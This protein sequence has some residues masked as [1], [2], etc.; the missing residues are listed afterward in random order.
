MTLAIV[1]VIAAALALAVIFRIAVSQ[2]LR[3]SPTANLT[4]Q[5]QAIDVEAFRNLVNPSE[6]D[7]LRQRLPSAQFRVVRRERLR[8]M[9]AY[10]QI[11]GSNAGLLVRM[12][13]AALASAD[14]RTL[15]AARE[16]VNEAL[17]LRRN[18]AVALAKIY[19]ALAW[20]TF[21]LTAGRVADHYDRL[22]RSAMLLGRLQNPAL[23]V[24]ISVMR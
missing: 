8:A 18:T 15:E 3:V 9:A 11:A 4:L 2:R 19:I 1:L 23:P 12:G 22:S 24:R 17:L 5:I 21:G 13:E 14:P 7:Y 16:L 20:P 10:V 6:D